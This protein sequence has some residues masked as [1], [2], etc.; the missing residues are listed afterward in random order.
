MIPSNIPGPQNA[1]PRT[2]TAACHHRRSVFHQSNM[3]R[4]QSRTMGST[5]TSRRFA[6]LLGLVFNE[7]SGWS[8]W[9]GRGGTRSGDVGD[10]LGTERSSDG[11]SR[12]PPI[13]PQADTMRELMV[14][15]DVCASGERVPSAAASWGVP[16]DRAMAARSARTLSR[17]SRN[18]DQL[19][20]KSAC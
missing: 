3:S 11:V 4:N 16:T 5:W 1:G 6:V 12:L 8:R 13:R 17:V 10:L 14:V 7:C 18:P 2:S 20:R 19:M 15:E 9:G